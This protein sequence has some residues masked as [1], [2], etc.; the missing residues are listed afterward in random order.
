MNLSKSI[1]A[2]LLTS[3]IWSFAACRHEGKN[4]ES[5]ND[6]PIGPEYYAGGEGTIFS[7]DENAYTLPNTT[8]S[9]GNLDLFVQGETFF[10]AAFVPLN[11]GEHDGLGPL[12]VHTA[13]NA[14]H[15]RNGRSQPPSGEDDL[16]SGLLIRLSI[17][18]QNEQGGPLGVPGFGGQ[19]QNRALEGGTPEGKFTLDYT[20]QIVEY[21]DGSNIT[22]HQPYI[23]IYNTYEFLPASV[24]KSARNASPVYGLGLLE[25]VIAEDILSR[26]DEQD[27]DGD[28][29][30]GRVNMVWDQ[31]TQ[32][33]QIGRFGWKASNATIIQQ[34][35]EAFNQD[36]G[37]TSGF[38]FPAENCD[39]QSNC[40]GG[41]GTETDITLEEAELVSLYIRGLAVPGP[42]NQGDPIVQQGKALFMLANCHGCHTPQ[43]TTGP[44]PWPELSN[45]IIFP[46]TDLLIHD[47]G[48][49]LADGRPD[50]E[51]SANEWRTPPLWGI[52]LTKS[53]NPDAGFLHDGR[54]S[55]LEEAI[56]WHGGEA[57]WARNYFIAMSASERAALLAFL[58]SL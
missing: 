19:L 7:Q 1:T 35:A 46:Y 41:I 13:C 25:A 47:L 17:A 51:A 3:I 55:S 10:N 8:L 2:L 24:L 40:N 42:R 53:I 27:A 28:Y 34:S 4:E 58:E 23:N 9:A 5:I 16:L 52:G 6:V 15:F 48:E 38:L 18:G 29:I 20:P 44:S 45:Q 12:F 37:I 22:L 39:G 14:C 43:L 30:S 11:E 33:M 26:V 36:M 49:V 56:V 50:Y 57:L 21:A 32:S 31:L 54:A